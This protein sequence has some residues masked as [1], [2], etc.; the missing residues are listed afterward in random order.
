MKLVFLR[1]AANRLLC[2]CVRSSRTKV[3]QSSFELH[4]WSRSI[5][6]YMA[7]VAISIRISVKDLA[8]CTL[9]IFRKPKDPA[10]SLQQKNLKTYIP[11]I[12]KTHIGVENFFFRA[13]EILRFSKSYKKSE[14]LSIHQAHNFLT[15]VVDCRDE[16]NARYFSSVSW[17]GR[18]ESCGET[19]SEIGAFSKDHLC[20][21][22]VLTVRG[23]HSTCSPRWC[24]T[25]ITSTTMGTIRIITRAT[26]TPPP[27]P[28]AITSTTTITSI[29][30]ST[31]WTRRSAR[32]R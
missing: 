15:F 19:S 3:E 16:S 8:S 18:L 4:R 7:T 14:G 1:D 23:R 21:F 22:R 25:S 5:I 12:S 2:T 32:G 9:L 11:K 13:K 24:C 6:Y 28:P 27:I 20:S 10:N 17:S 26:T 30:T 29:T 31:T